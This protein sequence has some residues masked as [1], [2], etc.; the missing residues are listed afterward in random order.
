MT[1]WITY[2]VNNNNN[3]NKRQI[4]AI[5]NIYFIVFES[6]TTILSLNRFLLNR[7]QK[8]GYFSISQKGVLLKV[9]TPPRNNIKSKLIERFDEE[10]YNWAGALV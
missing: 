2:V 7:T 10:M 4:C 1:K 5:E 9:S 6:F 8:I 3:N